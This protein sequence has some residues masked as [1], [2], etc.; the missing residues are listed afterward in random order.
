M[1]TV[2]DLDGVLTRADTMATLLFARLRAR[3]WRVI[4]VAALALVAALAPADG[5]VRP[6]CNRAI[7][8]VALRG[9]D[10]REYRRLVQ[11]AAVRLA[12]R[13]GNSSAAVM[14]ELRAARREGACVVS[15]ATEHSLALRYL[16]ELGVTEVPV[17][18]S[19]FE[20][21]RRGPRF[22]WHN[23]GGNKVDSFR[24]AHH[25]EQIGTFYTDSASDL[26][27]AQLAE[28]TVL[29]GASRR[30]AREFARAGVPVERLARR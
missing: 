13:R 29:V 10:E 2:F 26:P 23:V 8:S 14:R 3:P 19:R 27:L 5:Q 9:V 30:S 16:E 1:I 22:R 20:F 6:R 21:R 15:T 7:V 18:A 24:R 17:I 25:D 28:R 11:Q 4:P 12:R